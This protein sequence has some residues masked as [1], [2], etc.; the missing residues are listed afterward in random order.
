[1][2][3]LLDLATLCG[4]AGSVSTLHRLSVGIGGGGRGGLLSSKGSE[5]GRNRLIGSDG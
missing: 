2:K 3:A 5:R 1:V 4:A